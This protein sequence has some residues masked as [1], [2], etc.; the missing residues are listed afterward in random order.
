MRVLADVHAMPWGIVGFQHMVK[1]H[2][3]SDATALSRWQR[4]QDRLALDRLGARADD[5]GLLMGWAPGEV[6]M[7]PA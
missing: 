6:E 3:R 2:E 4:A 1:K 7:P 5:Q